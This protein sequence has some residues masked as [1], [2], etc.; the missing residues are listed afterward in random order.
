MSELKLL[1]W[2]YFFSILIITITQSFIPKFSGKGV[3]LGVSFSKENSERDE[4][5]KIIKEYI[6]LTIGLGIVLAIL[7]YFLVA[8]FQEIYGLQTIFLL[9]AIALLT[10]P[11]HMGKWKT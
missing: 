4:I 5:K 3:Y 9:L 7:I 6:R 2:T 1:Q 8:N 10:L 11:I